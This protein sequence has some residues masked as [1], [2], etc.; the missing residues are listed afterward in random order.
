MSPIHGKS[1]LYM[2]KEPLGSLPEETEIY[3]R[4]A[5]CSSSALAGKAA[6]NFLGVRWA[7][8]ESPVFPDTSRLPAV[9]SL[10]LPTAAHEPAALPFPLPFLLPSPGAG[11]AVRGWTAWCAGTEP[12]G[13]GSPQEA[14]VMLS[15]RPLWTCAHQL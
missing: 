13:D 2:G 9:S 3:H 8:P 6:L 12:Q 1:C 4:P 14:A 5:A 11:S 15:L 10:A 7:L